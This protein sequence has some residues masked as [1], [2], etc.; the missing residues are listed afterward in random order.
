MR[1]IFKGQSALRLIVK[2]YTDLTGIS[3]VCIR[4]LKPDKRKG[5]FSAVVSDTQNGIIY[6]DFQKCELNQSGWW[7]FWADVEF[8]DGRKAA[9][10]PVKIF[11]WEEGRI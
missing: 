6:H 7:V 2:T 5:S 8:G 3:D 1:K 11:V 4:Y 9:G 10:E